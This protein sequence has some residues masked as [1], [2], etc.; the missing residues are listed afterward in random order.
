MSIEF[1]GQI[2]QH[3]RTQEG[4]DRKRGSRACRGGDDHA[5][6]NGRE[7]S[8]RKGATAAT[9]AAAG[10]TGSVVGRRFGGASGT[11][12][13]LPKRSPAFWKTYL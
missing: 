10:P 4:K 3:N 9:A 1:G 11:C 8:E 7:S 2:E 12:C 13:Y 6:S 5:K